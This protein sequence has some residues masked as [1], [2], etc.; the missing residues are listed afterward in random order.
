MAVVKTNINMDG[1]ATV[2]L[3]VVG[4]GVALAAD[5]IALRIVACMAAPRNLRALQ[6]VGIGGSVGLRLR[7]SMLIRINRTR[8]R[9]RRGV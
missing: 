9:D 5:M 6:I 1:A 7:G 3:G 8:R 2:G 4:A